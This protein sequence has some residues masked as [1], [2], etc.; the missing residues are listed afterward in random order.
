M[1]SRQYEG[2]A[3]AAGYLKYRVV[4][5]EVISRIVSSTEKK[6]PNTWELAV[7]V[8]CGSGQSTIP[9]AAH[10]ATVVGTDNSAAQL[11]MA[12]TNSNPP[13]VSYRQCS[14]EE[15]PFASGEVDL[16]MSM[17]AAQW[18]DRPKF[19]MEA[20][21]V[22]RPGGCLAAG[23]HTSDAE[24]EFGDV[25]DTLNDI[26]REFY[27]ALGPFRP[28]EDLSFAKM[29]IEMF[30]SCPYPDKEWIECFRIKRIVPLTGYIGMVESYSSYQSLLRKD[31]AEAERL[32]TDIRNKLLSAMKVSSPETEVTVVSKF[33]YG[34]ARKP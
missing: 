30:D 18:F 22:L 12:L 33:F 7:D 16:V 31:P 28:T 19:L 17:S 5:H 15:L 10:F 2:K 24:L 34:L 6:E 3:H 1:D 9:L 21:R 8:G 4:P 27:A 32:S 11:E 25:S 13:N 29:Y 23:C 14:A 26:C 20:D